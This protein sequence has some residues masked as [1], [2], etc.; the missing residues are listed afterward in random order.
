MKKKLFLTALFLV[1]QI[2]PFNI[3]GNSSAII[4]CSAAELSNIQ[5]YEINTG[6]KYKRINGRLY[7]RLWSYKQNKWLEPEW[8]PVP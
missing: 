3:T 7:K 2:V 1:L 8:T 4:K 5:P 6:Y